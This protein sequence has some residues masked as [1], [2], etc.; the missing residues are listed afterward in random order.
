V[1]DFSD[2]ALA[3]ANPA[4]RHVLEN[5]RAVVVYGNLET[6]CLTCHSVHGESTKEHRNLPR[7]E[8]CMTCHDRQGPVWLVKEFEVSSVV[9]E[10]GSEW[11]VVVEER[12]SRAEADK[13]TATGDSLQ[14][15]TPITQPVPDEEEALF[16]ETTEEEPV[17]PVP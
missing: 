5:V 3:A 12:R 8:G 15:E 1:V 2:E 9:C 6:T 7:A 16:G 14:E 17:P 10:Y 11:D 13:P 4:D